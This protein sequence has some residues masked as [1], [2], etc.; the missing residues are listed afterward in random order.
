MAIVLSLKP[1]RPVNLND[2][3]V[4]VSKLESGAVNQ[5]IAQIS[6]S[7][8]RVLDCLG[9]EFRANPRGV[10]AMLRTRHPPRKPPV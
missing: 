6:E 3:A 10:A 2:L 7:M 4:A 5:P 9:V 1:K 8:A